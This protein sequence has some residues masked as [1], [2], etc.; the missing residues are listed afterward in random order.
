L[1]QRIKVGRQ[2]GLQDQIVLVGWATLRAGDADKR[3]I[4]GPNPRNGLPMQAQ[5]AGWPTPTSRDHKDGSECP[6]PINGLLGRK[7]W[8]SKSLGPTSTGSGV[9]MA[10]GDRLNPAF[11]RWLM[12]YPTAWDACAPTAMPSF[13]KLRQNSSSPFTTQ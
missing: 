10:N 13:R 1:N 3:G 4:L 7:V 6:V 11:A 9:A 12:G 8:L 5:Q 2:I